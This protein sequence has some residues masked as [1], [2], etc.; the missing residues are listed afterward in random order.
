MLQNAYSLG[1]I[2]ERSVPIQ[3]KTSEIL[4]K[5]QNLPNSANFR[6]QLP[7]VALSVPHDEPGSIIA[8]SGGTVVTWAVLI[9]PVDPW[10]RGSNPAYQP[11]ISH[12]FEKTENIFLQNANCVKEF[13]RFCKNLRCFAKFRKSFIKI[14]ANLSQNLRVRRCKF[15]QICKIFSK[16]KGNFDEMLLKYSGLSG[17]KACT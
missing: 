7:L 6:P 1:K 8:G 11:T 3:P 17:A 4:P 10:V 13:Q 5:I 16:I 2:L 12:N 9:A 15:H 14:D